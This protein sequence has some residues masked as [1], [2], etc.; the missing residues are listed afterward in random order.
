M[1]LNSINERILAGSVSQPAIAGKFDN[2]YG[3]IIGRLFESLVHLSLNTYC[4]INN[5]NLF[6]AKTHNGDQEIDFVIQKDFRVIACEVKFAPTVWPADGKHL[7]W[8]REKVGDDCYD[9][10]IINTGSVAY[11]REDGIA[12]VP[13]GLLGA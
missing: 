11:R 1:T 10:M 13:A 2:K 5:A 9:A 6:F 4:S 8:F 3:S 12:V 7:R